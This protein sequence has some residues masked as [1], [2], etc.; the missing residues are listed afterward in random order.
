MTLYPWLKKWAVVLWGVFLVAASAIVNCFSPL[1]GVEGLYGLCVGLMC[2][3]ANILGFTYLETCVLEQLYLH[4]LILVLFALPP[5]VVSV[6]GLFFD[7][8]ERV[9]PF[10]LSTL[11]FT[12]NAII[13][14]AS[15]VHY[16]GPLIPA[17]QLCCREL[18]EMANNSWDVY[19][20]LNILIFVV[21]FL[22]DGVVCWVLYRYAKKD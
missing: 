1:S 20:M 21:A 10:T 5:L 15:W 2:I 7:G 17:G 18:Q 22:L 12:I 4:P 8:N 16:W 9:A 19:V 11:M 3:F 6:K 14:A 13:M